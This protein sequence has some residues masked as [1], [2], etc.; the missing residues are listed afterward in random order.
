MIV[1][2]KRLQIAEIEMSRGA[3]MLFS[4]PTTE[5][6]EAA[7]AKLEARARSSR[8]STCRRSA[9]ERQIS[10]NVQTR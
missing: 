9:R 4:R 7:K 5:K 3:F 2:L 10:R 6:F 8:L 1:Q